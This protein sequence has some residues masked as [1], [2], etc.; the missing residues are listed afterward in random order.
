M[1]SRSDAML[2]TQNDVL[3]VLIFVVRS[4][5]SL[6]ANVSMLVCHLGLQGMNTTDDEALT[7]AL[8]ELVVQNGGNHDDIVIEQVPRQVVENLMD[9]FAASTANGVVAGGRKDK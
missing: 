3:H 2:M 7:V 9:L 5:A 1:M 8:W 4:F 6:W